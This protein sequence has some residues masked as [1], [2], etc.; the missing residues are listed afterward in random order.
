MPEL[1]RARGAVLAGVGLVAVGAFLPWVTLLGISKSGI[2][3]ADGQITLVV[4]LVAGGVT[5][6]G[7]WGT[8][9]RVVAGLGG[10]W[11][12]GIALLYISDPAFGIEER[13]VITQALSPGI[14][15]YLTGLGGLVMLASA[16]LDPGEEPAPPRGA[17]RRGGRRERGPPSAESVRHRLEGLSDRQLRELVADLWAERGW[18]TTVEPAA[19]DRGIDV[20]ARRRGEE[21]VLQTRSAAPD[22][23]VGA[24]D[25]EGAV[26]IREYDP[27]V[28]RILLVT[29]GTF[30]DEARRRAGEAGIELLDG[31][32]LADTVA[33]LEAYWVLD[34]YAPPPAAGGERRP[35]PERGGF[36]DWVQHSPR[37]PRE[38]YRQR[39]PRDL[40]FYLTVLGVVGWVAVTVALPV[41]PEDSNAAA[42]TGLAL[43]VSW[44]VL[45]VAIYRDAY[46]V[47][48]YTDWRP[49]RVGYAV[50]SLL[51]FV[52]ILIG[53]VYLYKRLQAGR[54]AE[55]EPPDPPSEGGPGTRRDPWS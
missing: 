44:A 55:R 36:L 29:T 37:I 39:A 28:D 51:W 45:P 15:L 1:S 11:C 53:A 26:S 41:V 34:D 23:P 22:S 14:G 12:L 3:A 7:N 27:D 42:A 48:R 24:Y 54:R 20:R 25:V 30:T 40:W 18:S 17:D 46:T 49:G 43:L 31:A 16:A 33:D 52:S 21:A 10:L 5:L 9:S 19:S 38:V 13:N 8:W 32:D 35:R 6:F 2:D 47:A 50:A 4:V